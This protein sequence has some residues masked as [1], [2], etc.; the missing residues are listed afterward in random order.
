MG[1][2]CGSNFAWRNCQ[3]SCVSYDFAN[4]LI[5]RSLHCLLGAC[6]DS[7]VNLVYVVMTGSGKPRAS[8][9]FPGT[10]SISSIRFAGGTTQSIRH[11]Q[12]GNVQCLQTAQLLILASKHR[13]LPM[14]NCFAMA[15]P[16]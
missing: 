12:S 10:N 6:Y 1:L 15:K 2:R 4:T 9:V 8:M 3:E 5:S 11:A 13:V 14:A 7:N 16:L